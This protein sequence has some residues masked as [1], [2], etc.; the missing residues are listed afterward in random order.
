MERNY[1]FLLKAFDEE[2]VQFK[3]FLS[4]EYSD[5]LYAPELEIEVFDLIHLYYQQIE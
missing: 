2:Q 4:K 5:R 3:S 1:G